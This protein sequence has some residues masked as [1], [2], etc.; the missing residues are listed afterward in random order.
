MVKLK[1][2]LTEEVATN[3]KHHG[4]DDPATGISMVAAEVSRLM[5]RE[6]SQRSRILSP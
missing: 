3:T 6:K 5:L 4:P 2:D 1:Q